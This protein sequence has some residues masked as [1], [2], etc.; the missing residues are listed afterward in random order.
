MKELLQHQAD[1]SLGRNRPKHLCLH[2]HEGQHCPE[3]TL[4]QQRAWVQIHYE[5]SSVSH[6]DFPASTV[7]AVRYTMDTYTYC[8]SAKYFF[9]PEPVKSGHAFCT[10]KRIDNFCCILRIQ[11]RIFAYLK[12]TFEGCIWVY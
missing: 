3:Y 1:Q 2:P 8:L 9:T 6:Q 7:I 12:Y 5:G 11:I 4:I 10:E